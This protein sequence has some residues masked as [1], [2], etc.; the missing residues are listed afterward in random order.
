MGKDAY[1]F[2]CVFAASH[3]LAEWATNVGEI[4][5]VEHREEYWRGQRP[6]WCRRPGCEDL[7]GAGHARGSGGRVVGLVAFLTVEELLFVCTDEDFGS[8]CGPKLCPTDGSAT[9]AAQQP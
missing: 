3:C 8:G 2:L 7:E 4:V 9:P 6:D 1:S 5:V